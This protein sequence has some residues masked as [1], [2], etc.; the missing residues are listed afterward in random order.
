VTFLFWASVSPVA[1]QRLPDNVS[2]EHYTLWFAPD[3]DQ[4]NFRGTATILVRLRAP[5]TSITLN[6][7][8]IKFGMVTLTAQGR[9]Q[10]ATVTLDPAREMAVLTVA[11]LI[12]AGTATIDIAFEGVL[13]D[14]LRGFYLSKSHGRKYA[15]TQMEATDAR[16]A[17]PCFDEPAYKATFD[18]SLTIDGKD[19]A[20]SNGPVVANKPGPGRDK[21]TVTFGRTPRMSSYLVAM[22]VGDFSCRE[23]RAGDTVVRICSTPDKKALTGFALDAA[24]QALTFFNDY[25]HIKYP[26]GKLDI[27]GIPDFSAGAMENA[28]AITVRERELLADPERAAIGARK[29]IAGVLAHEIAHQWFGDL[30]TMKWWDDIWLNEGF[31]TWLENKPLERW[32]PEWKMQL[33]DLEDT[34]RA[35]MS[36]ALQ[37]TR[38]IRTSVETPD[39]INE[40]FD[41]IA[42]QKTAAVLR[43][44]EHYV[45]VEAFRAGVSSYLRKFAYSNASGED[46][47]T[48]MA[49]VTGKPVDHIMASLVLQSGAP[50][51]SASAASCVA[52]S[53]N[54]VVEQ[55]RFVGAPDAPAA[56]PQTWTFPVCARALA[57]GSPT[58]RVISK[59][60][61]T[62][63][64]PGCSGPVFLNSDSLG[65]FITEY[66]S[67]TARAFA[68]AAGKLTT[69]ERIGLLA[70]EWAVARA[71]R[72][73]VDVYLDLAAGFASDQSAQVASEVT[74]R[75]AYVGEYVVAPAERDRFRAWIRST[76]GPILDGLGIPGSPNDTDDQQSRRASLISLV[77]VTGDSPDVQRRAR[78]LATAYIKTPTSL[79]GTVAPTILRVAAVSGDATLYDQYRARMTEVASD[80]EEFYRFFGALAAFRDPTLVQRTLD[81]ALSSEVRSQDT[82]QLI[83]GVMG[84][85]AGRTMAWSYVKSNWPRIT[86][87]LGTF[88]SLPGVISGLGSACSQEMESDIRQFFAEHPVS[89]ADRTLKQTLERIHA[90]TEVAARQGPVVSQWL[91]R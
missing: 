74:G 37:T 88:Q 77:G 23:G 47:W 46:F 66:G 41:A 20:I 90:C 18:I 81:F 36:D 19:T 91:H 25:F 5:A 35:L 3:F 62:I 33:D 40:V 34:R 65:Y 15:V 44:L 7:A 10:T 51:L 11:R 4:D 54:F 63:T 82:A 28:G 38:P 31:A 9:P 13:N 30:V 24:K 57:E 12:P 72:H 76:Y 53:S 17:F 26:F 69:A 32:K 2:P 56:A 84:Q 60:R 85:P 64:V 78:E 61:E 89:A 50:S 27:V 16:R 52:G 49:R 75:L 22:L 21:R 73:D 39:E 48:E 29:N 67:E 79:P 55:R 71:G 83:A 80:P 86:Q 45:G 43:M 68:K 14:K 58:C 6:A 70:D 87:K 59:A 1:A 42:Y 8:D